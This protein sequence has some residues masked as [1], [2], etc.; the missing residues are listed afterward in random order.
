M[1]VKF[2]YFALVP[3]GAPDCERHQ[4]MDHRIVKPG[5]F[6]IRVQRVL[7]RREG[8]ERLSGFE[9]FASYFNPSLNFIQGGAVSLVVIRIRFVNFFR[10]R[11]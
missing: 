1:N 2:V 11:F 10:N 8:W 4:W 6:G 3:N 9:R 7:Y 5:R